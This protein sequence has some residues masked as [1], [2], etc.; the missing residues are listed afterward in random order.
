MAEAPR[1]YRLLCLVLPVILGLGLW[2]S[3]GTW[4]DVLIDFGRELYVPWRLTEGDV[5]YRDL[6]YFNGPLSPYLN[7]F[8]FRVFG[9]RLLTLV[10]ANAI[11]LSLAVALIYRLAAAIAG[12][13]AALLAS[14]T[15]LAVFAFGQYL[16][17]G[18][19][20]WICPYS[21]EVTHGITLALLSIYLAW[22]N[23]IDKNWWT[24]AGSGLALGLVF[25]TKPEVFLAGALG[26]GALLVA[27]TWQRRPGMPAVARTFIPWGAAALLPPLLAWCLLAI[28]LPARD[29]LV[30]TLGGWTYVF[31]NRITGN[32][33]FRAVL[34]TNDPVAN[35]TAIAESAGAYA[36]L[37]AAVAG[38]SL[39][40]G[41]TR[42]STWQGP[43]VAFLLVAIPIWLARDLVPWQAMARPWSVFL[44]CLLA[45]AATAVWRRP[46]DEALGRAISLRVA[47]LAFS[48]AL[49]FKM[50]LNLRVMHYGFG[51]AMPA[52][53][54]LVAAGWTWLPPVV[55]RLGGQSAVFRAGLFAV[56]LVAMLV[57]IETSNGFFAGKTYVVGAGDD[58]FLADGRGEFVSAIVT[59]LQQHSD[60]N[61]T[62]AVMPEGIMVNYL[63]R[64][65][66]PAKYLVYLVPEML[67][68]GEQQMF[69]ELEDNPPDWLVLVH[70]DDSEYGH[71]FF[72][73]DYGQGFSAWIQAN[74]QGVQLFGAHPLTGPRF[75]VLI[76]RREAR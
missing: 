68:F 55:A 17:V 62:V 64:R 42:S 76:T 16:G 27:N 5:L 14:L 43:V 19:Y 67:M 50:L 60:P 69:A 49:S 20:N 71:R 53:M 72:G 54:M 74:Y 40:F 35:L 13:V 46:K 7:A 75:G 18:N 2:W 61:E 56:W 12:S 24:A 34:G 23:A 15:F 36:V 63:A 1:R 33:Y 48:L 26:V 25:L 8:W 3:W 9:P 51:L 11:V 58:R 37:I 31:D 30:G 6:A 73:R 4:P 45:S 44:L 66:A 70:R 59:Y 32:P 28:E 21:H 41:R 39:V 47:L 52:A 22:R 10:I 57:H 65:R 29:A 38:L